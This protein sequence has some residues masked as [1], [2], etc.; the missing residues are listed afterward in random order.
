VAES[1]AAVITSQGCEQVSRIFP[2]LL[3]PQGHHRIQPLQKAVLEVRTTLMAPSLSAPDIVAAGQV[4]G[5]RTKSAKQIRQEGWAGHTTPQYGTQ[6][7]QSQRLE[8]GHREWSTSPA[9]I[10]NFRL[11]GQGLSASGGPTGAN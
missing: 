10:A 7:S 8:R 9:C 4:G 3:Q 11:A 6:A 5:R 1:V 2:L